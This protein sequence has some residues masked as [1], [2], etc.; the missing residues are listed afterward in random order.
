MITK[1]LL[2]QAIEELLEERKKEPMVSSSM[3][4]WKTLDIW[5]LNNKERNC[6]CKGFY[7]DL[8]CK[9]HTWDK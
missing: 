4:A 5:V 8:S 1:E 2:L 6:I 7:R 9:K 3:T